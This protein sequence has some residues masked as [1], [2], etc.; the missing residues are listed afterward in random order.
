MTYN[1]FKF[2]LK[3]LKSIIQINFVEL[4]KK[5]INTITYYVQKCI[6][7]NDVIDFNFNVKNP[8]IDKEL[9]DQLQTRIT[10]IIS[11]QIKHIPISRPTL[12]DLNLKDV[13]Y[14]YT[15]SFFFEKL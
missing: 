11:D 10:N 12:S 7:I 15:K 13:Y 5:Q 9:F 4:N 1:Y 2:Q 8:C 6:N 3:Y 14:D